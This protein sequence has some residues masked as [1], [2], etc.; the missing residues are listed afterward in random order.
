VTISGS[1]VKE[2]ATEF[3]ATNTVPIVFPDN[4]AGPDTCLFLT[5]DEGV[6]LSIFI[7]CKVTDILALQEALYTVN[8]TKFYHCNRG[9][10]GN[11]I[12]RICNGV[13]KKM[14]TS[15]KKIKR[16]NHSYCDFCSKKHSKYI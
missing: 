8:P 6:T 13:T 2:A 1:V 7:Q 12:E 4:Y 5:N 9:S 3:F 15:F 11:S 10:S 16:S 14:H